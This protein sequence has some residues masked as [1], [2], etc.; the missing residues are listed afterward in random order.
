MSKDKKKEKEKTKEKIKVVFVEEVI[1][2]EVK[3]G[4]LLKKAFKKAD[5]KLKYPC[6]K[7]KCGK[8]KVQSA[9]LN[10]DVWSKVLPCVVEVKEPVRVRS[11]VK[12]KKQ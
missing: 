3:E 4:S 5:I 8:C 10:E 11:Y 2:V 7:G 9:P 6:N 1:E 12:E